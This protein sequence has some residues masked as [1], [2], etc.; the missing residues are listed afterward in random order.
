MARVF[1]NH[2]EADRATREYYFSLTAERRL[3]ILLE[4]IAS[5][6]ANDQ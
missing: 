6:H 2:E 3:E 5:A 1:S 4:I